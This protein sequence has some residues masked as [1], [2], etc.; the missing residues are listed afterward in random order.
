MIALAATALGV[1]LGAVGAATNRVQTWDE[2]L[3][4]ILGG[5]M[6]G[7][8]LAYLYVLLL[9]VRPVMGLGIYAGT[10]IL[11]V[12]VPPRLDRAGRRPAWILS[13]VVTW[14]RSPLTTTFGLAAAA[15]LRLTGR[16]VHLQ[17]GMVFIPAGR[18]SGVLALGAV[19]W[20][21]TGR[22]HQGGVDRPLACHEALHSRTVA[23]IGELGFYAAY[24]LIGAP[25]AVQQGAEWNN[26]TAE[27][28]G[29]PF[30]KTAHTFTGDPPVA[31]AAR[32]RRGARQI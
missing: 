18:G 2:R 20:T 9:G 22:M 5:A 17:A 16:P 3:A 14:T 10:G 28:L 27:G 24:L 1:F 11:G 25:W 13:I 21:Q 30:E 32:R 12:S 15:V 23:A 29:N 31:V 8:P 26:L 6:G 4:W 19:G 7:A